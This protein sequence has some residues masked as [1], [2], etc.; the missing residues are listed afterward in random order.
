MLPHQVSRDP[1]QPDAQRFAPAIVAN[2]IDIGF[3]IKYE[4]RFD[5]GVVGTFI[6]SISFQSPMRSPL[7]ESALTS[8]CVCIRPLGMAMQTHLL[9]LNARQ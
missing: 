6:L 2:K 7:S 1:P 4:L 5:D 3:L 8:T 9:H